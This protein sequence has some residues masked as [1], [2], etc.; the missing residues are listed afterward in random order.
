MFKIE[1]KLKNGKR[2]RVWIRQIRKVKTNKM[3]AGMKSLNE[4]AIP[5]WWPWCS[6]RWRRSAPGRRHR[7]RFVWRRSRRRRRP[8]GACPTSTTP[9]GTCGGGRAASARNGRRLR[10]SGATRQREVP[11]A[12]RDL[13]PSR[14]LG[15][16]SGDSVPATRHPFIRWSINQS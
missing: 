14:L 10:R 8:A 9:V 3:N 15:R 6:D 7:W 12:A 2:E 4:R 16:R 1:I 5:T 13:L 11:A